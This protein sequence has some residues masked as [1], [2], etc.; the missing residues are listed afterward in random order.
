MS[1]LSTTSKQCFELSASSFLVCSLIFIEYT[2]ILLPLARDF[3][4][5]EGLGSYVVEFFCSF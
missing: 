3:V 1:V 2:T 5:V 4:Y